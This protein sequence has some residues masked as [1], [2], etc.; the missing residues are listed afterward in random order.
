MAL[1][2]AETDDAIAHAHLLWADC[3]TAWL[4]GAPG[5]SQIVSAVG[6]GCAALLAPGP[7]VQGFFKRRRNR[8]RATGS[9]NK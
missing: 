3:D 4:G 2:L 9:W 6:C 1:L 5:S 7:Q 8:C